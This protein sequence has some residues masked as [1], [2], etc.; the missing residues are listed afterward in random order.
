MPKE[1]R[2]GEGAICLESKNNYGNLF[3][4]SQSE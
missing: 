2:K 3:R 1:V 4:K